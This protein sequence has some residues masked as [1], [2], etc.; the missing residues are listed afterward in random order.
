M[1]HYFS[2][3]FTPESLRWL[4]VKGKNDEALKLCNKV[5]KLNGKQISDGEMKLEVDEKDSQRLGDVRD[6]FGSLQMAKKTLIVL[7]CW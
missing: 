5:A 2:L 4:I 3:R 1:E 6:L 7:Y